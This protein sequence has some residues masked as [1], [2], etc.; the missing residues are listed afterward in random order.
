MSLNVHH[1]GAGN[2]WVKVG[3]IN[4]T[5][6]FD[7]SVSRDNID[8]P[9]KDLPSA[10]P[11]CGYEPCQ[12]IS[13]STKKTILQITIVLASV[14]SL[15]TLVAIVMRVYKRGRDLQDLSWRVDY[16]DLDD[17]VHNVDADEESGSGNFEKTTV[18]S[19][20]I[21]KVKKVIRFKLKHMYFVQCLL[22]WTSLGNLNL[23]TTPRVE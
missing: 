19:H 17:L 12:I 10:Y 1:F 22:F 4:H 15:I 13:E 5:Q 16:K 11:K 3:Q 9:I 20:C 6:Q 14:I 21:M 8:W 23:Y 18:F 2:E 7:S